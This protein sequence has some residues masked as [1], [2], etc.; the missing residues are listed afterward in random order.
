MIQLRNIG[1]SMRNVKPPSESSNCYV[2]KTP[3]EQDG[4]SEIGPTSTNASTNLSSK[5]SATHSSAAGWS[6]ESARDPTDAMIKR[7]IK[8]I[9]KE[10]PTVDLV[11]I[12]AEAVPNKANKR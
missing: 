8:Q 12:S 1:G 9:Q 3:K 11:D 6:D 5:K 2:T 4:Q 7:W 10:I